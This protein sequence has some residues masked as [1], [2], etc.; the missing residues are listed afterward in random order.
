M[1]VPP[2]ETASA[3][4]TEE[5]ASGLRLAG[6]KPAAA[7]SAAKPASGVT[8]A[9]H[10]QPALGPAPTPAPGRPPIAPPADALE[11]SVGGRKVRSGDEGPC[12]TPESLK[13]MSELSDV[14]APQTALLPRE[15]PLG[16]HVYE[17]RHWCDVT[18]T[19]K[20]SA[21][22]HKPLYFEE[23]ALERYGH[24]RF[25]YLQPVI[26]GGVFFKNIAMWPYNMGLEPPC[27]CIYVLGYY[28]PGSCAPYLRYTLPIKPEAV[29][30]EAAFVGG[31]VWLVP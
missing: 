19:W 10:R 4:P 6:G 17:G 5:G 26:S 29:L 21:L 27:E 20:A 24:T 22:C 23:V 15:C 9:A 30:M 16:E 14:I 11:P 7:V 12:P 25:P 28:R 31:L 18:M 8:L 1:P 3:A 13:K 2:A